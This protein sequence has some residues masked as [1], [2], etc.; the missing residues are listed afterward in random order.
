MHF[1]EVD[2]HAPRVDYLFRHGNPQKGRGAANALRRVAQL[3]TIGVEG[4]RSIVAGD[5]W[6]RMGIVRIL[7]FALIIVLGALTWSLIREFVINK[8]LDDPRTIGE[9]LWDAGRRIHW[10]MGVAAGVIIIT[11]LIRFLL[12]TIRMW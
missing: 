8:R 12:Q 5:G 9:K 10:V 3:C 6:K 2:S 11:I 4:R 7:K 1:L